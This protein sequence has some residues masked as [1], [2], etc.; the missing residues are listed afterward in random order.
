[1]EKSGEAAGTSSDEL[2]DIRSR[3]EANPVARAR[4]IFPGGRAVRR[5]RVG[6]QICTFLYA[7]PLSIKSELTSQEGRRP[8]EQQSTLS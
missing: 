6:F 7:D 4:I 1:M 5:S 3:K 8:I 2:L